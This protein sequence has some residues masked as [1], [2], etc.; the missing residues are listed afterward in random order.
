MEE[1]PLALSG[2]DLADD[3]LSAE[4]SAA[5]RITAST[6]FSDASGWFVQHLPGSAETQGGRGGIFVVVLRAS[7]ALEIFALPYMG[8]VWASDD[9][10]DLPDTLVA[11]DEASSSMSGRTHACCC[12]CC[13]RQNSP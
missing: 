2:G 7:G 4:A 11:R 5:A 10:T 9:V 8:R 6:L 13:A 1:A 3:D 12:A